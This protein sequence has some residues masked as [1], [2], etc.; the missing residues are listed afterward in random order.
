MAD[1]NSTERAEAFRKVVED[2]LGDR[3]RYRGSEFPVAEESA[4]DDVAADEE[5]R[6][7]AELP[8]VRD[9]HNRVIAAHYEDWLTLEIPA[10]G[11]RR[12]IDAVKETE[13]REKVEALLRQMERD[14][15]R[16][17]PPPD[18]AILKRVRERLGLGQAP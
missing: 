9:H 15:L 16:M 10:L 1:V 18:E 6:R 7:L 11:D 4:A 5:R 2:A 13:G 17:S 8:E 3:A 14:A 12:P